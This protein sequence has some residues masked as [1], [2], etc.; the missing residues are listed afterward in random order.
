[1]ET[2]KLEDYIYRERERERKGN[3][4]SDNVNTQFWDDFRNRY[5]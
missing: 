3:F 1:M 4:F 5:D 2:L